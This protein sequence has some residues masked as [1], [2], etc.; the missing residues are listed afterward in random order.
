M[1]ADP[2]LNVSRRASDSSCDLDSRVGDQRRDRCLSPRPESEESQELIT[3]DT[4]RFDDRVERPSREVA[5][6]HRHD[7][8]VPVVWVP[9][10]VVASSDSIELPAAALQRA[11]R[12][13]RRHRR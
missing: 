5:G 1:Q 7:H 8:A 4:G 12:S 11:H 9:E 13:P 6:V 10:D 2:L 3:T